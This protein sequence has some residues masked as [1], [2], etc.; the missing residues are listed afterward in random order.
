M[1]C[2]RGRKVQ[3]NTGGG[4]SEGLEDGVGETEHV[5]EVGLVGGLAGRVAVVSRAVGFGAGLK[6]ALVDADV[7][8]V[9]EV[10]CDDVVEIEAGGR[11]LDHGKGGEDE[12]EGELDNPDADVADRAVTIGSTARGGLPY[13]DTRPPNRIRN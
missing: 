3:R 9:A 2:R 5:D 8:V 6:R 1:I 13:Q 7:T 12:G 4:G 11:A 10:G